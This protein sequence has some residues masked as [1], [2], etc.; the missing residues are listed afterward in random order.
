MTPHHPQCNSQAE[1]ANK[2]IAKYLA[3]FC[4][5]SML[6]Y[7]LYLARL[8]FSYNTSFHCSIKLSPFYLTCEMEP[9]LPTLPMPDLQ[10]KFYGEST[11]DD[12]SHKMLF[13]RE[14]ACQNK[15]DASDIARQQFD[16]KAAPHKFLPQQLVLM[17]E[18]SFLHKNQKLAP[19]WSGPHKVVH[20]K[21][22]ANVEI[23]LRQNNHKTVVHANRFKPYF[24]AYKNL[25][26]HPDFL[27][28]LP[29]RQQWP[30]DVH[31]PCQKTTLKHNDFYYLPH[32]R[33]H[34]LNFPL[35]LTHLCKLQLRLTNSLTICQLLLRHLATFTHLRMR[36][37][38]CARACAHTHTHLRNPPLRNLV[39]SY[40]RSRFSCYLSCKRGRDWKL[41]V[42]KSALMK[43]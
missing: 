4:D 38:Q 18:H 1:V 41:T 23:Q 43:A 5:D 35:Q 14:V 37:Q 10:R 12:I 30:D 17:D 16:N 20:L 7:E 24:V 42:M 32:R 19:K 26:V 28:P 39:L 29:A 9:R 8:M 36:L 27:P 13:A 2:T 33:S 40:S 25:A 3:S 22:D 31:P 21:G 6:D 34:Q 15:E 11:T